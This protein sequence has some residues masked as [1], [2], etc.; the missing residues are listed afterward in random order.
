MVRTFARTGTLLPIADR[1]VLQKPCA[2]VGI[3]ASGDRADDAP[4]RHRLR[5]GCSSPAMTGGL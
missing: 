3:S 4:M 2:A 1:A 5:T